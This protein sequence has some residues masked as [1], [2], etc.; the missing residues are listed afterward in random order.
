MEG[1]RRA[2]N[3]EEM[4]VY[5]CR[6]WWKRRTQMKEHSKKRMD[7]RKEVDKKNERKKESWWQ[8]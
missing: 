2:S 3:R 5:T 6:S 4:S 1:R 7:K 8:K